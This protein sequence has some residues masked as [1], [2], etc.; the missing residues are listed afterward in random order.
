MP[1][2]ILIRPT[3]WPQ[4][5]NVTDRQDRTGQTG[6]TDKGLIAQGEPFYKRSPKNCRFVLPAGQFLDTMT[7]YWCELELGQYRAVVAVGFLLAEIL[8][9][10]TVHR[11]VLRKKDEFYVIRELSESRTR[12]QQLLRWATV[13]EKLGQKVGMSPGLTCTGIPSDIRI[14]PAVWPQ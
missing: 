11:N 10:E 9:V 14:L 5:T 6:Q 13:P 12:A 3:V 1:S 8:L 7:S 2:F 4:C